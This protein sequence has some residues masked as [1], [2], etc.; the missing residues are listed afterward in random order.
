MM[1]FL[2][3]KFGPFLKWYHFKPPFLLIPEVK[4]GFNFT[5]LRGLNKKFSNDTIFVE[6]FWAVSKMV[7]FASYK[8]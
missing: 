6:E 4:R 8:V 5:G 2:F 1:P 7:P 3:A